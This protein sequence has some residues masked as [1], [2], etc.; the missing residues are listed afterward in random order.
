MGSRLSKLIN[1]L[2]RI[3]C[4]PISRSYGA[5]LSIFF[6]AKPFYDPATFPK[7]ARL[8]NHWPQIRSE[9][10]AV[11]RLQTDQLPSFGDLAQGEEMFRP[12][13]WK[14]LIFRAYGHFVEENCKLCPR[15]TEL[16]R[17]I[18]E[19][20]SA[21]FSILHPHMHIP[22][23]RGPFHGVLRCHLALIV[24]GNAG[25]AACRIRVA[26]QIRT[27]EEG[28][29]LLFDDTFL[30]EVWNDSDSSRVVLF[31]DIKKRLPWPIS[32]INNFTYWVLSRVFFPIMVGDTEKMH[33][34]PPKSV[35]L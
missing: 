5:F 2:I 11:M 27:W 4:E 33:V 22:P 23:H 35:N 16:I 25:E 17:G 19:I 1:K 29:L 21:F 3:I 9:L 15:T 31:M 28:K 20:T 8:E 32:W 6:T 18:P 7:L 12:V 30:H 24:P 34:R 13:K 10:D 14:V 26:D